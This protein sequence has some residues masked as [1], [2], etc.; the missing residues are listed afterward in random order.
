MKQNKR[1]DFMIIRA[2]LLTIAIILIYIGL[3]NFSNVLDRF[4]RRDK[5]K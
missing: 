2:M 5:T 1:E 3:R 4:E